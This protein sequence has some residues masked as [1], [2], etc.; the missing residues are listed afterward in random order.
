MHFKVNIGVVH[1][2]KTKGERCRVFT[3]VTV[4]KTVRFSSTQW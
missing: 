2:V 3:V 1:L 4:K